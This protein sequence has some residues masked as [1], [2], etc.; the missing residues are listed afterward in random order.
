[1]KPV[2]FYRVFLFLLLLGAGYLAE[3]QQPNILRGMRGLGQGGGRSGPDSF[4]RR[5]RFADSLTLSYR[6]LDSTRN[7]N[8]DTTIDDYTRWFPIPAHYTYLG[9]VGTAARSLLFSPY[10]KSGWD[11]GFHAFD[12]Y[13]WNVEDVRFF[14]TT[15]PYTELGYVLGSQTQQQIEI[16]HTQNIKPY[17]NFALQYRLINAPGFFKSQRTNHNNYLF[18]SRYQSPN[19]RYTNYLAVLA[20]V[21][22]SA[23]NGGIVDEGLLYEPEYKTRFTIPT[24]LGSSTSF[25]REM[26]STRLNTGNRYNEFN[27]V[28]RQQYDFGRKDSL[29]TDTTVIPLFYPRV[30]FEH[31]FKLGNYN[32]RYQ[33]TV[34]TRN[35]GVTLDSSYYASNYGIKLNP[36]RNPNDS[37]FLT[38]K[39]REIYNDFSI[40]QFPDAQNLH[41]FIKAG[42]SYQLLSGRFKNHTSATLHNI[43]VHGEYRNR[44]RNKKWDMEALGRLYLSG[45]NGGDYHGYISLQRILS[46]RWGSLKVG[47]ENINRS[48]S[49]IFDERSSFYLDAPKSFG[50]ENTTHFFGVIASPAL[51]LQLT[52]DYYLMSNYLY[53][54]DYRKLQQEN[55]LFNLLRIGALKKFNLSRKWKWYADVYVQQKTGNAEINVPLL[56]TRNRLAFEGNFFRNL[57]LSTGVEVRYHTPYNADAYSPVLGRFFYQDSIQISNRPDVA[58]YFNFRIRSFKAYVRAENLNSINISREGLDFTNN[59]F[60]AP[61]YPYPGLVIRFGVYWSFVN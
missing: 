24:R 14:N 17:W 35:G 42:I 50:K 41:Q 55:A 29:V 27:A 23:E 54:T 31:T 30:R 3:A 25:E 58:A 49:F 59:N 10:L 37:V 21:L 22:Q 46:S 8:L 40:Y 1:M 33:D 43:M 56:F 11:P 38:D 4:A 45:Y 60:A 32:Y 57:Y 15:R 53:L 9:N 52:G 51:N 7:S 12:A 2:Y 28:L 20:N 5:D 34:V 61:D 39:W 19:K 44:T 48:P 18:S 36:L 47:F 6:Q 13:K 16:L 26:F